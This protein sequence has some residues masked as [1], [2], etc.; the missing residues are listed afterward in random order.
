MKQRLLYPFFLIMAIVGCMS[1][2]PD[3]VESDGAVKGYSKL[4]FE[5]QDGTFE[6]SAIK[7]VSYSPSGLRTTATDLVVDGDMTI[8]NGSYDNIIVKSGDLKITGSLSTLN[9]NWLNT[10]LSKITVERDARFFMNSSY[11]PTTRTL[12][13]VKGYFSG[14]NMDLQSA[15]ADVVNYGRVDLR[16]DLKL[17]SD[18]AYIENHNIIDVRNFTSIDKGLF[19][20]VDCG[21]LLTGGLNINAANK[22]EGKGHIKVTGSANINHQLTES[23]DI[24]IC[25]TG[26]IPKKKLGG[27]V[28]DCDPKCVP[29]SLPVTIYD[30]AIKQIS[31]DDLKVDF[32]VTENTDLNVMKVAYSTDAKTWR[33][34]ATVFPESLIVG[35][36]FTGVFSLKSK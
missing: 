14:E 20:M 36:Q 22:I 12:L 17:L 25:A 18:G 19:K 33:V 32:K 31:Q 11:A 27:A 30:L 3:P 6:E 2:D 5:Y 9:V 21:A 8:V 28:R 1:N 7:S 15:R 13:T 4:I 23:C 29:P 24:T 10:S 35:Q 16:A 34:V 26:D